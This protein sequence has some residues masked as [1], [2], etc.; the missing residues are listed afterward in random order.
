MSKEKQKKVHQNKYFKN[1]ENPDYNRFDETQTNIQDKT[2][3]ET[4]DYVK[5][6][7]YSSNSIIAISNLQ[8]CTNSQQV[9]EALYELRNTQMQK[10]TIREISNFLSETNYI[11]NQQIYDVCA[12]DAIDTIFFIC[13]NYIS[14]KENRNYDKMEVFNACINCIVK[15]IQTIKKCFL[16][17]EE[18]MS[19]Y[20]GLIDMIEKYKN[21]ASSPADIFEEY[22]TVLQS[23]KKNTQTANLNI[24]N[25]AL[26]IFKKTRLAIETMRSC[27]KPQNTAMR[28]RDFTKY[29]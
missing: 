6:A 3:E 15:N 16:K 23:K 5:N 18:K 7:P 13:A 29:F 1:E 11:R 12:S 20:I 26:D 8:R 14:K 24:S 27:L 22:S 2:D 19:T 9:F 17:D 4:R 28:P 10:E 25:E 21:R